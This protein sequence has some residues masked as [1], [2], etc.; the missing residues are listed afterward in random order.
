MVVGSQALLILRVID[1]SIYPQRSLK[2]SLPLKNGGK[3]RR[4]FP[5]WGPVT[6]QGRLLLQYTS[7][8]F[9]DRFV[10]PTLQ[11]S[12]LSGVFGADTWEVH[13]SGTPFWECCK[14]VLGMEMDGHVRDPVD[15]LLL[16]EILH[17]LRCI[18]PCK[19]WDILHIN[20]CRIS[21]INSVIPKP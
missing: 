10:Q 6:F 15:V 12:A 17:H 8:A 1:N 16:E 9:H 4:S 7:G 19:S 2:A 20:W 11:R 18:K 3:G 14:A 13:C 21:S 5:I